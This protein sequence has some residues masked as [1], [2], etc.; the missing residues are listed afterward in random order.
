MAERFTVGDK[1]R[2]I[3]DTEATFPADCIG[4]T[5]TI[6]KRDPGSDHPYLLV[7]DNPEPDWYND[8]ATEDDV[9]PAEVVIQRGVPAPPKFSSPEEAD[10]WLEA[11]QAPKPPIFIQLP[12]GVDP[13]NV[14][15]VTVQDPT[16]EVQMQSG[17]P[18]TPNAPS[19]LRT[20][21]TAALY[22]LPT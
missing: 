19:P 11:Q 12:K 7:W 9:A 4:A 2:L 15:V 16:G 14:W 13:G 17:I 20:A 22:A 8:W 21:L 3:A 1:V 6:S 10:A 5:A 18:I